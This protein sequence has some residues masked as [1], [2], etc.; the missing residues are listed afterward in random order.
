MPER[1]DLTILEDAVRAGGDIARKFYGG[2]YKRWSKDGGS[3][4]TEADLAVDK[5]L[6]ETLTAARLALQ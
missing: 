2:D 6:R 5:H 4:V 1:D 3:P